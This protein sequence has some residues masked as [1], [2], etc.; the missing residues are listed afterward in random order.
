MKKFLIKSFVFSLPFFLYAFSVIIVDPYNYFRLSKA[1]P[2]E[3]KLQI[4]YPLNYPLWKIIEFKNSP[5]SNI[6]LGDSRM[7]RLSAELI[8]QYTGDHYYNFSFGG[9]TIEEGISTFWEADK[10][11]KLEKVFFGINFNNF[12]AH[13]IRNR[14]LGAADTAKSPLLYLSNRNVLQSTYLIIKKE[15]LDSTIQIENPPMSKE[16]FWDYKLNVT[17]R[18]FYSNYKYP[19]ETYAKLLN[20]TKYCDKKDIQ[21]A[22]VILPT[23]ISLQ[24]KVEEYNLNDEKKRFLRE[25]SKLGKIFN[26]DY[27]N[28]MTENYNNFADPFHFKKTKDNSLILIEDIFGNKSPKYTK[29]IS[30]NNNSK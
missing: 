8:E 16:K 26:F 28:A 20:I 1:I 25:L 27:P 29:I 18:R 30:K 12:S 14:V 17:A 22:F 24:A 9:G 4:S 5:S 13:N 11:I 23:H 6:L 7:N 10:L 2:N 3:I 19:H 15:A 21:I